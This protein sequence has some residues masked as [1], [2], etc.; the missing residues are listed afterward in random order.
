[1]RGLTAQDVL[2]VVIVTATGSVLVGAALVAPLV[3]ASRAASACLRRYRHGRAR[4]CVRPARQGQ[5]GAHSAWVA[6]WWPIRDREREPDFDFEPDDP[7]AFL[8]TVDG[9]W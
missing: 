5:S 7:G 3:M 2:T 6:Q 4:T 8:L 9:T 1:M